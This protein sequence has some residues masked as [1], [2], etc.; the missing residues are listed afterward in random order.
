MIISV[1]DVKS[2]FECWSKITRHLSVSRSSNLLLLELSWVT[3]FCCKSNDLKKNF[4]GQLLDCFFFDNISSLINNFINFSLSKKIILG[5]CYSLGSD[6]SLPGL[7]GSDSA[8]G[9][10]WT[11]AGGASFILHPPLL[12]LTQLA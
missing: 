11:V 9:S 4:Y 8:V 5:V 3:R 7:L 10:R 1:L 2:G 6:R 12:W